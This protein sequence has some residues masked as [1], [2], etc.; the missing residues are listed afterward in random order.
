MLL[1]S[2]SQGFIADGSPDTLPL[3]DQY[4]NVRKKHYY[5]RLAREITEELDI[6]NI[7][8]YAGQPQWESLEDLS[9]LFYDDFE[10]P[11]ILDTWCVTPPSPTLTLQGGGQG[12]WPSVSP[13]LQPRAYQALR[14]SPREL[15][16]E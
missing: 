10:A 5:G 1:T 15:P 12:V 3:D 16:R 6:V 7:P 13:G 9:M 14:R 4:D 11:R 2:F 8:A